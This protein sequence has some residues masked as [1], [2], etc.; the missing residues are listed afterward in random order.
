MTRLSNCPPF[1][2]ILRVYFSFETVT[3]I[4]Y[5]VR[6][7]FIGW[8]CYVSYAPICPPREAYVLGSLQEVRCT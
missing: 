6:V 1:C 7:M 3:G 4:S 5:N 8:L 2:S